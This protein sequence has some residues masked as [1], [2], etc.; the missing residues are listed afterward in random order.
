MEAKA[1]TDHGPVRLQESKTKDE[2]NC[3][4]FHCI[5]VFLEETYGAKV[6]EEFISETGLA[7][8]YLRDQ[9]N[10]VSW[11]YYCDLLDRLVAWTGDPGA[12][13][14]AGTYSG[15]KRSW[16]YLYYVFLAFGNVG[17]VIKKGIEIVPHFNKAEEWTLLDLQKNRRTFRIRMKKGY[18]A[19]R[20]CCE[21][22]MGQFAGIPRMFGMPLGRARETQCQ[23]LGADSCVLEISWLNRPHRLFGLAGLPLGL[24]LI[25]VL[26]KGISGEGVGL[27]ESFFILLTGY[28]GGSLLGYRLTEKGNIR[29]NQEQSEAL[30]ESVK[31]IE[32][33]YFELQRAH[34]GLYV[35][36][37]IS[38]AIASTLRLEEIVNILLQ[39]VVERLGFDRSI[40]MLTDP[41]G[42]ALHQG[43]VYG[44]DTLEGFFQGLRVPLDLNSP[45]AEKVLQKR[46]G[47]IVARDFIEGNE[48]TELEQW[49]YKNTKTH[50][51]V[52][53]PLV[54]KD[55]L[56]GILGAD[57]VRSGI[58]ITEE[59]KV[60]MVSLANQVAVAIE[61]AR[62]FETIE[63]LNLN[64]ENKVA[65]RT[66]ELK[67]SLREL[68]EAQEQLIHSEKMSSLGLLCSGLTHEINNPINF[69]YNGIATLRN[70]M[71]N[72]HDL[73]REFM[74]RAGGVPD[75]RAQRS[76][77]R[78]LESIREA[79]RLMEIIDKGLS[80]TRSLVSDLKHFS[81]KDRGTPQFLV[82]RAPIQSA[83][84]ILSHEISG[85][86]TIHKDLAF[87]DR[88]QGYP[89]QLNQVFLNVLH[90]AVQA[91][92]EQGNIWIR[93][94]PLG[95][96][97]VRVSI[98]DDGIGIRAEDLPRIF[99]PF[100]T[101]KRSGQGT[102]L[103]MS[104]CE[105]IMETHGGRMEVKSE[106]G[107]GTEVSIVLPVRLE[108]SGKRQ[109]ASEGGQIGKD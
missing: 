55:H 96:R 81:R 61:N 88:V 84:T 91:I 63:D 103:G 45:M 52:V 10:W 72:I 102:G 29:I 43:K 68:K 15:H 104:I 37:E 27:L 35:L 42:E 3:R 17:Q 101:T 79:D 44:D 34:D 59:D 38:K 13:Y 85:R 33:K 75:E 86:I 57:N 54:I 25:L 5:L 48:A 28:L 2:V 56:L 40:V 20:I 89:D 65:E 64:L 107:K 62:S 22:R 73:A 83:L 50:E 67:N 16:G 1:A 66:R 49:I 21:S 23:A 8:E 100:F 70:S 12:P 99:E 97:E 46:Q 95:T 7:L 94:E 76:E 69:A 98:R 105:R 108:R 58:R 24:L 41:A 26:N 51:F 82:I 90:N 87:T 80:R 47:Q 92:P 60:L 39:M 78:L 31:V 106:V 74:Q 9:N 36:H 53:V 6:L 19:K 77:T 30:E 11:T 14:R 93:A 18:D 4:V 109:A 32:T 71:Q